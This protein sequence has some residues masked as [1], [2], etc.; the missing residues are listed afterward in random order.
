HPLNPNDAGPLDVEQDDPFESGKN[1][2]KALKPRY[3]SK[4]G[5]EVPFTS[6]SSL[7]LMKPQG[8]LVEE[9]PGVTFD[10]TK[11]TLLANG[12]WKEKFYTDLGLET[13]Q[14]PRALDKFA[15]LFSNVDACYA[16]LDG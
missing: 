10:I 16:K 13:F 14:F 12:L 4:A 1:F 8:W 15:A 6:K 3:Q 5:G 9:A 7:L 2:R 11:N